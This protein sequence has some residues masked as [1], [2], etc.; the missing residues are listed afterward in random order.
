MEILYWLES[1]RVPFLTEI[2]LLITHL[3][4]ETAFLVTALIVFWCVDKNRG[5]YIMSV[6]FCGTITNQFLKLA[7]K[8]PRPWVRDP[9]F[10]A[11]EDAIP[12]A[13][14]YSFPSGHCQSAVGTFG[15]LAMTTKRKALR[16][17]F[18]VIAV[19]VPFSRMYLGVHTPR[20]VIVGCASGLL[21]AILMRYLCDGKYVRT[22]MLAMAGLSVVYLVYARFLVDASSM[23]SYNYTHGVQNAFTLMGAIFGMVIVQFVDEKWLHFEV[24]AVWWAQ[25][26]K[27]VGGLAL[28]LLVKSGLKAPFNALFGENIGRTLRYFVLVLIAGCLW[29]LS[30]RF[31]SK[32]GRKENEA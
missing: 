3:G 12:E 31:F 10:T 11:V 28:A 8:V 18:I 17:I 32:L 1:I 13:T 24:K 21:L 16:V 29:P 7:Y 5:Y 4:E 9:N 25:I 20:D 27:V 15:G 30:F 14:G 26:L 19:L 6:G 22:T 23:D 2:L